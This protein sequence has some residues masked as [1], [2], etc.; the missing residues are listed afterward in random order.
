MKNI[1]NLIN[2][3]REQ[4]R[5]WNY[6][7]HVENKSEVPDS[8]Y[9]KIIS[10]LRE[11]EIKNP[12]LSSLDSPTKKIGEKTNTRFKQ[13]HHKLPM[14]S[15]DNVFE[16]NGFL[17]FDKR[18]RDRL[19]N[20]NDIT[21]CCELK[22][23]GVAVSLIY[24]YGELVYAA[25]RG[26]GSIGEDITANIRTIRTVPTHIGN[27]TNT[28]NRL[29]IRGEIFISKEGFL[30]LNKISKNEDGKEF[31]NSRNAASGSL[32]QL[33]PSIT[34]K[35]PLSFLCYGVGVLEGGFLPYSHWERLQYLKK[36]GIPIE[37][38]TC[39]CTGIKE[40]LSFYQKISKNR[41]F[42]SFD[43]DGIVLKID[44]L[45]LQKQLGFISR[46]P[47]WAIAYKFPPNEKLTKLKDIDFQVG[48]SGILTPVARLEP[49]SLSG[50]IVRSASLH[51]IN[52]IK[53]MELMIG[54]TVIVQ[55]SGD[56]IPKIVGIVKSRRP[57][58]ARPIQIPSK[59]PV[60]G[61]DISQTDKEPIIFCTATLTCIAQRKQ[62]LNHFVSRRAMNINGIG[63]CVI[64][65][66]VDKNLVKTPADIFR[67]NKDILGQ[68]KYLGFKSILNLLNSIIKAKKTTFSRFLYS[69]GIRGV[70]E[71]TAFNLTKNYYILE[72]LLQADIDSL[73]KVDNIGI[74]T[75][76][77]VYNFFKEKHNIALI[78]DL[79]SPKIGIF[80]TENLSYVERSNH[81]SFAN[82]KVV[83]TGSFTTLSQNEIKDRL[84]ILGAIIIRRVS[85]KVDILITGQTNTLNFR[86]AKR[87]NIQIMNEEE[88]IQL[89]K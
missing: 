55:R 12:T 16:E 34:A 70:G 40:V 61:A 26:D 37:N 69:L 1:K 80:W 15:L 9:D 24:E 7:Y 77:N 41:I 42:L 51:N 19:Q 74:T 81:N 22:L 6:L 67:L 84:K 11:L 79:I 36:W 89:L 63:K 76:N 10:Q 50:V 35:R 14:L 3:Y 38:H 65:E 88:I 85:K 21:Y 31:A 54:D 75:A 72:K 18:V 48:R 66:L 57:L 46:S 8:E 87:L 5:Y 47:R 83:L 78:R 45:M 62:A 52:T 86:K 13:I 27:I 29:E 64:N 56:V 71:V 20:N 44:D 30:R 59:C 82:K 32:R 28:P 23:D 73:M 17:N 60:C 33:D 58:N 53:R 39:R 25:T 68:I 4:L 49:V 43:I 2:Q